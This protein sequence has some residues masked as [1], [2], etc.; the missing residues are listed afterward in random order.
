MILSCPQLS[1]AIQ[2]N[3]LENCNGIFCLQ[4]Q[5]SLILTFVLKSALS[6]LIFTMF[7]MSDSFT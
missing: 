2:L 3:I 6:P 1:L 7:S 5:T 4:T